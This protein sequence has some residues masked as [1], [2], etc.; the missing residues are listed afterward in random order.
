MAA[1]GKIRQHGGFLTVII[2]LALASFVIG[3]KAMDLL[4]KTKPD[5]DHT[6]IGIINGQKIDLDYFSNKVEEQIDNFKTNQKK[7]NITSEERYQITMQVWDLVKKETLLN[8]EEVKVGVAILNEN[9]NKPE[10]SREEYMDMIVGK[11]PHPLI[12]QNFTDQ[13][14][15]RFNPQYV[16][17]FLSNIEQGLQSDDP[18][19]VEQAQLSDKQWR[20]LTTYIKEDR[21]SQKYYNLIKKGYYLPTALAEMEYKDRN[22]SEKVRYTAVRYGTIKDE[23]VNPTE[24]DYQAYY[25]EHKNEF[26]QNKETRKIDYVVWNVRPSQADIAAIEKQ[27]N[28]IAEEFKTIAM[29]NIPVYVNS[30]RDSRYD[31][32]WAKAGTLSP[33]I[34]SIAFHAE[35]GTVMGPWVENNAYH[36]ARLVAREVRP[37][38]MRASH[39]LISYGGAYG[40]GEQITRTKIAAKALADSLLQV[41][42]SNPSDFDTL[43][44]HYSDDPSVKANHGDMKWFADGQMVYEFNKACIDHKVGDILVVETAYGYHVLKVTG[45]KDESEKVRVAQINLQITYSKETHNKAFTEATHF[46]SKAQNPESFDSVSTNS[47]LNVMKGDYIDE[48][49]ENI[50]GVPNSRSIVRWLFDE[51]NTEGTVSDVFDLD[52]QII[53]AMVSG[54]RPKGISPLEDVKDF[55]KPLVI[56][57]AKAKV[58]I[59]KLKG[60]TD[61]NQVASSNNIAVDTSDYLTFTTYSLPKYGPEQNVQG[62]MFASE[63][64]SLQGPLKGDQGVY[65]FVVDKITPAPAN[66][67]NYRYT[68]EQVQSIFAQTVEQAAYNAVDQA[69][70]IKD[71]RSYIY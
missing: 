7:E 44:V 27:A 50:M 14:T 52:N 19:Q 57:E 29:E 2:G 20:M 23:D 55:I 31:S 39:L 3:P 56:R 22:S 21:L 71:F 6:S 10:I 9:T 8:Q 47:Q 64:G 33:F 41:A 40:A 36:V 70:E 24:E 38:S 37:D 51:K 59:S 1:I 30:F 61:I 60:A 4:F 46:A 26:K 34:D 42:L 17:Q 58:L 32:T 48:M 13:K 54:I 53:V 65:F 28:E 15:G 62:H 45:K 5:F 68:R 49:A 35:I 11:H 67:V 25:D 12:V 63:E 69:A 16:E 43:A 66:T 18:K